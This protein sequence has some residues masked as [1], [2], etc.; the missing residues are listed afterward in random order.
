VAK[1]LVAAGR[2]VD[3]DPQ[4]ALAHAYAARAHAARIGAVREAVGVTAYHA[5]EW[6]VALSELRAVRRMN[7]SVEHLAVEA[8]CERAL[9][10]PDRALELER[11]PIASRLDE[12]GRVELLIVASGARRDLGQ[13]DSAVVMLQVPELEALPPREWS[14]R[15]GYAYADALLAAG[16]TDEAR[17]WFERVQEI[18]P[19]NDTGAGDRLLELDGIVLDD[20][21]DQEPEDE[22]PVDEVADGAAGGDVAVD[23]AVVDED[24][25]G[26]AVAD[27]AVDEAAGGER[28]VDEV[29]E[30]FAAAPIVA[31]EDDSE[32]E[33]VDGT[34]AGPVPVT[35]SEPGDRAVTEHEAPPV[36]ELHES[37]DRDATTVDDAE[38]TPEPPTGEPQT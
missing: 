26:A 22:D 24:A 10:R 37:V 2:L 19:Y 20:A 31:D 7:G 34:A 27:V 12:A 4:A 32:P 6:A 15:L 11:S 18:D 16:R 5:G 33:L 1:H 9:G 8:D 21:F 17:A 3:E 35:V 25:D 30:V 28:A 13:L 14:G 38:A 36:S 29:A 23:E